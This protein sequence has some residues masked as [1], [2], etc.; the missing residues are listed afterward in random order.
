MWTLLISTPFSCPLFAENLTIT[1]PQGEIPFKVE[2]ART[3]QEQQKGLMFRTQLDQDA[4]M[5]FVHSK[6]RAVG[7]W[8]KNTPL[9]L[10][11]I[12]CDQRGKILAIHEKT[13][14]YSL[15]HIGPIE[16]VSYVLEV[17][18]GVVE[19]QGISHHCFVNVLP[20][21]KE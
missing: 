14:P 15:K 8:M 1:C 11:M 7:M 12:F 13:T 2:L 10:D 5:L 19:K 17:N 9:S 3:P 4:G 16:A 6:P 21:E 20:F 18:G